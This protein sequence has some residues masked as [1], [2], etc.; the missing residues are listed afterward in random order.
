M[1]QPRYIR[2]SRGL[3]SRRLRGL[4]CALLGTLLFS[5]CDGG[6]HFEKVDRR[7]HVRVTSPL[8]QDEGYCFRVPRDW[9][10]REKLEGADIVCLSPPVKG[11]FRES[12]VATSLPAD[13][14]KDPVASLGQGAKVLEPG[15]GQAQ[16]ILVEFTDHRFSKFTLHQLIFVHRQ[17]E[18]HGVVICC[19]AT[20]EDMAKRRAFFSEVVGQAKF[21]LE[22]CPTAGGL[23]KAF[24][25]P[26]V[27]YSPGAPSA[28]PTP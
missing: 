24:P 7:G 10:I 18:G 15:D 6:I 27:T 3:A 25:T 28:K 1:T 9:E 11:K 21:D 12:I 13:Q 22:H 20:R 4:A 8:A 5:A 2:P 14:L 17:S 16:P 23:P 19:T 26:E